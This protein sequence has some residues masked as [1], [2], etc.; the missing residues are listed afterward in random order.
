M[1]REQIPL[2]FRSS[3]ASS[4]IPSKSDSDARTSFIGMF[5]AAAIRSAG[6][7]FWTARVIIRCS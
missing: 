1:T 7:P 3:A 6:T 4:L 5:S 2:S